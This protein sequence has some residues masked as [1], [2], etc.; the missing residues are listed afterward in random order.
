MSDKVREQYD[1]RPFI[2][3][4]NAPP[5]K[6]PQMV[7]FALNVWAASRAA[8]LEEAARVLS[9]LRRPDACGLDLR[10]LK[11][12]AVL[13]QSIAAIRALLAPP[14]EDAR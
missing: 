3:W 7:A 14:K 13:L 4:W 5:S 6:P 12:D 9:K 2:E 11:P 1:N 10:G 8:A